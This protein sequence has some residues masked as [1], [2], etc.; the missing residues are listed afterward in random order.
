MTFSRGFSRE[1]L[2]TFIIHSG[3]LHRSAGPLGGAGLTAFSSLYKIGQP[4][5][6]EIIF[7]SSAA[8]SVGSVVAQLAKR[9]SLTVIGP[10]GSDK[11]LDFIINE[12][13]FDDGFNYK[14]EKPM[15]A[16]G[17]LAPKGF[18]IY[19]ENVGGSHLEAA[20]QHIRVRGRVI[21]LLLLLL[22][23]YLTSEQTK[24]KLHFATF[25]KV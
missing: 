13:G 12:L 18:D 25:L 17:R 20:L 9:E 6:G 3:L 14:K 7:V 24:R 19:Y 23:F 10:V 11:K 22:L 4:K 21:V 5:K 15:D 1:E 16:L 2:L 8:G